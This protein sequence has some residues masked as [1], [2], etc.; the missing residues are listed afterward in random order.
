MLH[1]LAKLL[2]FTSPFGSSLTVVASI[3]TR[4]FYFDNA[5]PEVIS[6]GCGGGRCMSVIGRSKRAS[7]LHQVLE[8]GTWSE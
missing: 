4:G 3:L 2:G 7:P 5:V 8:L 1:G 6:Y